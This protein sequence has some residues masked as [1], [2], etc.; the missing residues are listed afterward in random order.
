MVSATPCRTKT[1]LARALTPRTLGVFPPLW[2]SSQ[3]PI[4]NNPFEEPRLHYAT[5]LKGE[6]DYE[7]VLP[8]RRLFS[9]EIQTIPVKAGPQIDL[10]AMVE[11]AQAAYGLHLVNLLRSE[12]KIW[13]N[14]A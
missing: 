8:G 4:L 7:V 1:N 9:P 10:P 13:R 2:M 11:E 12:V 14:A 6:L 3:N 5:N